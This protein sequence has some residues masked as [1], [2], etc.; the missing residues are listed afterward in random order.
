MSNYFEKFNE[1][2]L[3]DEYL[4]KNMSEQDF[5]KYKEVV[6]NKLDLDKELAQK[7]A[8]IMKTWAIDKGA[9]HYSH[10]FQPLSGKTAEKNA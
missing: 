7:I 8:D 5:L 10:W 9:T 2:V 4:Q 1:N 6:S 3:T